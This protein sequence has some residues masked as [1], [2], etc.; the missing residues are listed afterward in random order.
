MLA[1]ILRLLE[2][3]F[4]DYPHAIGENT[5]FRKDLKADSLDLLEILCDIEREFH[6]F[7]TEEELALAV[8]VA[9][10]EQLIVESKG[11][12]HDPHETTVRE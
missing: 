9:E 3:H 4:S 11:R 1:E 8:T 6:Q 10:L 7:I 12:E 2:K 5:R